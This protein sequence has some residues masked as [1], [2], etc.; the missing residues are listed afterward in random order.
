MQRQPTQQ[1]QN[2]VNNSLTKGINTKVQEKYFLL[3]KIE[4]N[5]NNNNNPQLNTENQTEKIL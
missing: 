2:L 1:P 5:A 3:I 4:N